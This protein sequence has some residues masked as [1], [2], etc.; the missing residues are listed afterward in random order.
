[1]TNNSFSEKESLQL[2]MQMI[3]DA[4][5]SL[6][7]NSFFFLVWGW[8][9]FA[10]CLL[11]Y[12]MLRWGPAQHA[13]WVW[14]IMMGGAAIFTVIATNRLR[15]TSEVR[16]HLGRAIIYLWIGV[17]CALLSLIGVVLMGSMTMSQA[18]PIF[19]IIYGLATFSSGGIINFRP[20]MIGGS[21][22]WPIAF[23]ATQ[24]DFLGQL[25]LLALAVLCA[26]LVPG[27]LLRRTE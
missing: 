16:S 18:Y 20:L 14:P 12:G 6:K 15:K 13:H 22:C 26:Y 3:N 24:T 7:T 19:I 4:K 8:A 1:M 21:L 17:T 27:Y 23:L 2:I 5:G 25:L 10:A 9:V 11:H